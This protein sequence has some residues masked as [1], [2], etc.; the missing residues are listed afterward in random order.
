VWNVIALTVRQRLKEWENIKRECEEEGEEEGRGFCQGHLEFWSCQCQAERG[1]SSSMCMLNRSFRDFRR[2]V[3]P[4]R[5]QRQETS[6]IPFFTSHIMGV[7]RQT[8]YCTGLD[9]WYNC[10]RVE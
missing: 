9:L 10:W 4:M 3:V 2:L 7:R 6:L 5:K 1:F 8:L